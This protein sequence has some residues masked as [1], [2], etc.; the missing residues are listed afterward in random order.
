MIQV[1]NENNTHVAIIIDDAE[2]VLT[3]IEAEALFVHLGHV[4]QDQDKEI[5]NE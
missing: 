3:R 5:S 1:L 2:V 4:L